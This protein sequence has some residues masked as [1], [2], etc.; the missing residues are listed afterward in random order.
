MSTMGLHSSRKTK[1]AEMSPEMRIIATSFFRECKDHYSIYFLSLR[2]C[3]TFFLLLA[4]RVQDMLSRL[5][6]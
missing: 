6:C 5:D 3:I 2:Y 1:D 4:Y